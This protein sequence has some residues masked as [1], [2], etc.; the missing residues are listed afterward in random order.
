MFEPQVDDWRDLVTDQLQPRNT[1]THRGV[2]RLLW[3]PPHANYRAYPSISCLKCCTLLASC[4][5]SVEEFPMMSMATMAATAWSG[6]RE[7]EKQ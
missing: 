7:A 4:M 5:W 2:T 3:T 1:A 6:G